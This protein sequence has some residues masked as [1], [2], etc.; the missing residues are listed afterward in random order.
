VIEGSIW[1]F[2][3]FGGAAADRIQIRKALCKAD[4]AAL[5]RW[6]IAW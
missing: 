1:G 5:C 3:F 4:G 6:E 2:L